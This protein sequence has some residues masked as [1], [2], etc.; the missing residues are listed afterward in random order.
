ME[1]E[2]Q[3][4]KEKVMLLLRRERELCD[5]RTKHEQVT[6]WLRLTQL[7]PQV[8]DRTLPLPAI[9]KRLRKSLLS[10]LRLQKVAFLE[11]APG[12]IRSVEPPGPEV[13]LL[14]EVAT[15]LAARP[16]GL[17][18]QPDEPVLAALARQVG[19]HRFIWSRIRVPGKH[20]LL[21]VAGFD[22]ATT[23]FQTTFDD[24]SAA[25]IE[26]VAQHIETLLGNLSLLRE[27]EVERDRLQR[28]NETL[29]HRDEELEAANQ[30]LEHR[31]AERTRELAQR[32]RDMRLMLDNVGQAFITVDAQ[33]RMA[34][35]RSAMVDAWFGPYL[36]NP[37]FADYIGRADGD[38]AARFAMG[39]EGL[40]DDVL[41]RELSLLQLPRRLCSDGRVLSCAYSL[42][43]EGSAIAGLV[44]V[45]SDVT[46]QVRGAEEE[47]AQT[48][49]LALFQGLMRDRVGFM[50][51]AGESRQLVD[52]LRAEGF[53]VA[54]TR[55][56][57]HTLKGNAAMAGA[58]VI[59]RLCHAAEEEL[60]N[61]QTV[62]PQAALDRLTERWTAVTEALTA[63]VGNLHREVV[64][65][66]SEE[67][68]AL[69]AEIRRGSSTDHVLARLALWRLEPVRVP[70]DRLAQYARTLAARLD[71]CDLAVT[72]DAPELRLDRERWS[73]LWSALVQLVRNAVDHGVEGRE[74]RSASGKPGQA[75]LRLGLAVSAHHLILEI[76][77]DGR[78]IDWE[79][80]RSVARARG[81]RAETREE[82]VAA[83]LDP[84]FSTRTEV[85]ETSGRGIGLSVV[86]DQVEAFHGTLAVTSPVEEGRGGCRWRLSF[87]VAS[88]T[89]TERAALGELG[90]ASALAP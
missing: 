44:I 76:A 89:A 80:V 22:E 35:E 31:V 82:L 32:T 38:F 54:A 37:P 47:E 23:A 71:K 48:E 40:I 41:P 83:L 33:G 27:L 63:A 4:L 11:L 1:L 79:R 9:Y 55:R 85:S 84:G 88:F 66:T 73:G 67:I 70:L 21:L 62:K 58:N 60:A 46:D 56:L 50:R 49:L 78:G 75:R 24:S 20:P 34:Q 43:A 45:I 39:L 53:E 87:P 8:F 30:L 14:D 25:H 90:R 5:I 26:N 52:R 29:E 74:E 7:L 61:D 3:H 15:L 18:N 65:V 81:L 16:S 10:G 6:L 13:P 17:C 72:T 68:G 86:R 42:L 28:T 57:L 64:E 36:G 51:F 59:V 69:A 77:D 12:L 2:N 19:L